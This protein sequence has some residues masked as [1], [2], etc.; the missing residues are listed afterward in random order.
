M[1]PPIGQTVRCASTFLRCCRQ[2]SPPVSWRGGGV[3]GRRS[4]RGDD[5]HHHRDGDETETTTTSTSRPPPWRSPRNAKAEEQRRRPL[6]MVVGVTITTTRCGSCRASAG[7]HPQ[8]G[9]PELL[10]T[11]GRNIVA[12]RREIGRLRVHRPRGRASTPGCSRDVAAEMAATMSP[13]RWSLRPRPG[14]R[15]AGRGDGDSRRCSTSTAAA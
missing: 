12:L 6:A 10:T 15:C 9:E 1:L 7:F 4:C 14:Q 3:R 11:E 5:D 13:S 2:F 8:L